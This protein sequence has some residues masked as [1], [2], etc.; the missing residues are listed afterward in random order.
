MAEPRQPLQAP[1]EA[2]SAT[3]AHR[4]L[5]ARTPDVIAP[6]HTFGSVTDK[7]SAIVLTQRTS[8]GWYLGFLTAA[9]LWRRYDHDDIDQG[10]RHNEAGHAYN[11]VNLDG[12]G[13]IPVGNY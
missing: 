7:I 12:H 8:L 10:A 6:G 3:A 9:A 13:S 2:G 11:V 1:P 5:L 4:D